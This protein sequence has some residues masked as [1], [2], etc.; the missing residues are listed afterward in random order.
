M[1]S[2]PDVASTAGKNEFAKGSDASPD[3]ESSTYQSVQLQSTLLAVA[4][5]EKMVLLHANKKQ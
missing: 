3:H 2:K 5:I 1:I 4:D